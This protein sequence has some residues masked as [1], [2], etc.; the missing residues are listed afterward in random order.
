M[1]NRAIG[2]SGAAMSSGDMSR[3]G[4]APVCPR[5]GRLVEA[6]HREQRSEEPR[7]ALVTTGERGRP[8]AAWLC[9]TCGIA[10]ARLAG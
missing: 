3:D 7:R 6:G 1:A 2:L 10:R 9:R 5:C 8:L 4:V